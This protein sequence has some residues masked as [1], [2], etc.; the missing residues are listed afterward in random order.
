MDRHVSKTWAIVNLVL[1][2][3]FTIISEVV[4]QLMQSVTFKNHQ[5]IKDARILKDELN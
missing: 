1:G 4:I 3:L 5:L 2:V